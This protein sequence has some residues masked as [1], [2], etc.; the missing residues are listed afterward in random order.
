[1]SIVWNLNPCK[2]INGIL[3]GTDREEVRNILG[4]N[5]SEYRKT[6]FSDNTT[7]DYGDFQVFYDENNKMEAIE[8]FEGIELHKDDKLIFP[9]VVEDVLEV[10]SDGEYDEDEFT[11]VKY[12][13]GAEVEDG[14]LVSILVGCEGYY[15]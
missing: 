7:D 15:S 5:Y 4:E 8:I 14:E 3:F 10:F 2:D 6:E 13:I 11:S 12:S 1:M 9:A